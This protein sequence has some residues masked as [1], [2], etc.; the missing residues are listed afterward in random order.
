MAA[1]SDMGAEDLDKAEAK[2]L[3]ALETDQT[4]LDAHHMLGTIAIQQQ[5]FER[6]L[7]YF[8]AALQE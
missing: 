4:L 6:S 8:Q 7:P 5:D 1:Q 2:L 3:E